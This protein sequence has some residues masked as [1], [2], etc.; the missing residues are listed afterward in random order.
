MIKVVEDLTP[1]K[2]ASMVAAINKPKG[3]GQINVSIINRSTVVKDAD[4]EAVVHA[5]Q[6][7]VSYHFA[8]IWGIDAKLTFVPRKGKPA[9]NTWWL[10]YMDNSDAAGALGY[11][12]VTPEGLPM[13]KVFA[14]TDLHYGQLHS[15]TASHELLEMLG[16]PDINLTVLVEKQGQNP[17]L[18]AYENCDACEADQFGYKINGITVSDFVYP[19]WFQTFRLQ[20]S[21]QFDYQNKIHMPLQLL[22]G[23]YIG[24]YD[25]T[26]SAGWTQLTYDRVPKY[27]ER[28]KVGTRRE[29]RM[30]PRMNW[31]VSSPSRFEDDI[32]GFFA[33]P[34]GCRERLLQEDVDHLNDAIQKVYGN[35]DSS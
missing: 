32:E 33:D 29:R 30:T 6:T 20:N 15:V 11:H 16:D 13:G 22:P 19:T 12:D 28:A 34:I 7:Q 31:S 24:V 3:V 2:V 17:M 26:S 1:D 25:I 35:G 9:N 10:V 23:G 8:P 4:V 14:A 27:S 18:Y 21:V 5:L